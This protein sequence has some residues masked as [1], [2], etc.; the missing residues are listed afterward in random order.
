MHLDK[1]SHVE[2]ARGDTYKRT[3]SLSGSSKAL[4]IFRSCGA[5]GGFLK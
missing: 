2:I 3:I 4:L 5:E 1:A